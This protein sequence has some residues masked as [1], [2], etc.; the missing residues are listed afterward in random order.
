M[1]RSLPIF[2]QQGYHKTTMDDLAKAC[3]LFK[4]SFYYYFPN[5]EALMKGILEM[6]LAYVE[7]NVFAVAYQTEIPATER[8]AKLFEAQQ[9]LLLNH[10][11]G[12]LFGNTVLETVLV[13][14]EFRE[15]LRAF[16]DQWEAA[17]TQIFKS[18]LNEPEARKWAQDVMIK[19]EGALVLVLVREEESYL[20]EVYQTALKGF[21]AIKAF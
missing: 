13:V 17:L 7:K 10:G 6:G 20:K 4:G 21:L 15:I 12:C 11:A 9:N 18:K 2:L 5:K 8:L 16:F 19:V 14:P 1:A 3:G